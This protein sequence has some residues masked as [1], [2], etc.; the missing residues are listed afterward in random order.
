MRGARIQQDD[1]RLFR[2]ALEVDPNPTSRQMEPSRSE[3]VRSDL[4]FEPKT[5]R[6]VHKSGRVTLPT[7]PTTQ[8][9]YDIKIYK[10]QILIVFVFT[11]YILGP[12]NLA[13]RSVHSEI[14]TAETSMTAS[15]EN[16]RNKS[17]YKSAHFVRSKQSGAQYV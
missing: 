13:S 2:P 9:I 1:L 16:K 12:R 3:D 7:P 5:E 10:F 14:S 4:G 8:H 17:L 15:D 6:S 11:T